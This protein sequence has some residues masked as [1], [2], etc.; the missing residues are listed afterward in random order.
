MRSHQIYLLNLITSAKVHTKR[1]CTIQY[2]V[3]EMW[4]SDRITSSCICTVFLTRLY[5]WVHYIMYTYLCV[6]YI[7]YT[8]LCVWWNYCWKGRFM[9]KYLHYRRRNYPELEN[10]KCPF[11]FNLKHAISSY[12]IWHADKWLYFSFSCLTTLL[13]TVQSLSIAKRW[14]FSFLAALEIVIS[15]STE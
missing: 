7:M 12:I 11:I 4:W 9:V 15:L 5:M 3:L 2:T 1:F 10:T 14:A 13:Y 6:H 8:Y